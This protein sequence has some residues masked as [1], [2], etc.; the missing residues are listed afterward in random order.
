MHVAAAVK[1]L[2][3]DGIVLSTDLGRQGMMTNADGIENMIGAVKAAGV[4]DAD[5]DKMMRRNPARL[6][7][8]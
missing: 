4:S 6:L 8:S 2:G 5:I 3:A 1:E 7:G